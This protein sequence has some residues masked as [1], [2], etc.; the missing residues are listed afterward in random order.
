MYKDMEYIFRR[1]RHAMSKQFASLN[2]P[3]CKNRENSPTHAQTMIYVSYVK[4][5]S[6]I[7]KL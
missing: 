4:P 3:L 7:K 5:D 1:K 6:E 2:S